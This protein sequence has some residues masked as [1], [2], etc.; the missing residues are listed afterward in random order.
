MEVYENVLTGRLK[1]LYVFLFFLRKYTERG[2]VVTRP[3]SAL[4]GR[5]ETGRGA[6]G[7]AVGV[8][9]SS[10]LASAANCLDECRAVAASQRMSGVC[11]SEREACTFEG[12][13]ARDCEG[14]SE[15]GHDCAATSA[16]HR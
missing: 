5:E 6:G 8:I 10:S 16:L 14:E 1:G 15:G 4:T 12:R 13:I 7:G 11:V 3:R 9:V 2:G